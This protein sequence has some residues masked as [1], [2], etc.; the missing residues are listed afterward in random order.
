M[1][2]SFVELLFSASFGF[3][4]RPGVQGEKSQMAS[5]GRWET[6]LCIKFL[7]SE[8][9]SGQR[10]YIHILR[11]M[12]VQLKLNHHHNAFTFLILGGHYHS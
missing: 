7:I 2:H 11:M 6:I 5:L 9:L 3:R 8:R 1:V 4:G 10:L 12:R